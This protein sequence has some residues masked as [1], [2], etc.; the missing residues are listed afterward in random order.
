MWQAEYVR[1]RLHAVYPS[2]DI[3]ILGLSTRG[4]E[5]LDRTLSKVGGKGLFVKELE[6]AMA[7]GRAH[8][9]VHSLKDVPM[10][11]PDGFEI[12]AVLQRGDPCDAFVSNLY[13]N[14]EALPNGAV[15]GTSSLRR[16]SLI[17]ARFPHL[18]VMPLRGNLDTRLSK[19]D[20][21]AYDAVVLAAAGL[22]RLGLGHRIAERL[23]PDTFIP[24]P[25]QGALALE[26]CS[27]DRNSTVKEMVAALNDCDTHRAVTAERTVSRIFGGSCEV[28]LG[29][30]ASI[31]HE[32][33]TMRAMIST[34][35]GSRSVW[36]EHS[37]P[38][39]TPETIGQQIATLLKKQGAHQ[40]LAQWHA[41]NPTSDL[42]SP[43]V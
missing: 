4:D 14:L 3:K 6:M 7:D 13:P 19:L 42:S 5:I 28:P 32:T 39:D 31:I 8:L 29:A 36:V 17:S 18:V 25:G 38:A 40:I 23:A 22:T 34:P 12:A 35:N 15:V 11:L 30:Y 43:I 26:I 2:C 20:N 24:A 21:G 27:S 33:L 9:A 1:D 37:G 16:Q 41:A 10:T